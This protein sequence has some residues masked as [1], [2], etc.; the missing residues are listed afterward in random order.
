MPNPFRDT[1][2]VL[3]EPVLNIGGDSDVETSSLVSQ[4]VNLVCG[5][6]GNEKARCFHIGLLK[7]VAG[8]GFEP[9]TFRL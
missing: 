8:A 7:L 2:I 4:D 1:E 3:S 5:V 9:T 6:R